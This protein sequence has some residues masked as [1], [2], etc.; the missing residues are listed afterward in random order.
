[1]WDFIISRE[2]ISS[3]GLGLDIGGAF[4]IWKHGTQVSKNEKEGVGW[5]I[6]WD[7]RLSRRGLILLGVGFLLQ[8]ISNW[9]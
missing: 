9:V 7:D 8:G 4:L 1:M 6:R 5:S 2:F 3:V